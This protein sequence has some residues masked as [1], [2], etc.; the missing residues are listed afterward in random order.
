ME[1]EVQRTRDFPKAT[2]PMS[3]PDLGL[4]ILDQGFFEWWSCFHRVY[5]SDKL[6][7]KID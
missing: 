1:N 5:E 3:D 4:L 7:G 6:K 2:D